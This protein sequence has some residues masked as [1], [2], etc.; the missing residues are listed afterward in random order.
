MNPPVTP[1][2]ADIAIEISASFGCPFAARHVAPVDGG[3]INNAAVIS[4][5]RDRFFVKLNDVSR[6]GMFESEADGLAEIANTG[7]VRAPS[8]VCVGTTGA[9]AF[10]V[11]EHLDLSPPTPRAAGLLGRDLARM[12][13][14]EQPFFGWKRDNTI[15][16]TPQPNEPCSSWPEFFRRFRLRHQLA[17]TASAYGRI[18]GLQSKGEQ[19]CANLDCFFSGYAA[20]PSLLHGDLWGGNFAALGGDDPVI[21]DPAVYYG[22]RESDL[23]MTELFGGFDDEFYQAYSATLPLDAGYRVRRNLYKLYHVLNH[24]NHFG[25]VYAAQAENLMDRLLAE[26]G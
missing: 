25:T 1:S 14:I 10:L 20:Y 19:L 8:V 7:T 22:D 2:W 6:L 15:G 24:L 18:R 11:L 5:E 26:L 23:A 21:F 16:V 17:L 13:S 3:C 9:H 12:H 4:S